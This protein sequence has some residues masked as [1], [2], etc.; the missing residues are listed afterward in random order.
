FLLLIAPV[1]IQSLRKRFFESNFNTINTY[2]YRLLPIDP[3]L[4]KKNLYNLRIDKIDDPALSFLYEEKREEIDKELSML[5]ERDSKNFFYSSL[6]RYKGIGKN[7]RHEARLILENIPEDT[8]M[9]HAGGFDAPNF[10]E[11]AKKEIRYLQKQ[12]SDFKS[13]VHIRNDVNIIMVSRGDL[14]PPADYSTNKKEAS[15]IV[16]HEIGT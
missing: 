11:L 15:G 16:Q 1:N 8:E 13:Q 10:G 3:D 9:L 12:T 5:K 4:L 14:Y 2:H 7:V 6:R